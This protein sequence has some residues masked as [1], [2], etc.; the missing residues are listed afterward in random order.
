[1]SAGFSRHD[2]GAETSPQRSEAVPRPNGEAAAV[3]G[4][5]E[6]PH[7]AAEASS[8][9]DVAVIPQRDIALESGGTFPETAIVVAEWGYG[10][11]LETARNQVRHGNVVHGRRLYL[12]MTLNG[13]Q[14]AVDRMR[15]GPRFVIEVRWER[16][17]G[18]ASA[19]TSNR[20][21]DLP[22]GRPGLADA[23]EQQVRAEGFSYGTPGLEGTCSPPELGRYR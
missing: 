7:T 6:K 2:R 23:L 12:S 9:S 16:E 11:S 17:N 21:T 22:I 15:A 18:K 1:M 14:T 5:A 4:G 20:V 8:Q 10:Y 13:T 3:P 19:G